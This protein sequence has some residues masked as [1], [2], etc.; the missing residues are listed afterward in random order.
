MNLI[1]EV[2]TVHATAECLHDNTSIE[3]AIT[4][5]A[6]AINAKLA[7]S[8]PIVLCVMNGG[9][10]IAG[11]LLTQL[12]FPLTLDAIN[13]S[14]YNNT[15]SGSSINWLVKPKADLR[16]RTVLLIDD[17]LDEGITLKAIYDYC[18][19]EGAK[20]VYIAAL[21]DKKLD[22]PKPITADFIGIEVP[23]KYLFGYGMDYK[24]YL[25][26]VAGIF[27]CKENSL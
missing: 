23:N 26:N 24:G 25:R 1:E 2:Q 14:R 3:L 10:V 17:I 13:A 15:T 7:Q 9:I 4:Q 27:A 16:D 22:H 20:A 5:M 21:L 6:H 19:Q 18:M 12:N 8:N 11:K